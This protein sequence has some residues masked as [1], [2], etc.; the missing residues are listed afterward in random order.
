MSSPY[1]IWS[2]HLE[3][4]C[5]ARLSEL[6]V[7]VGAEESHELWHLDNLNETSLVDIEMSPGLGEVG[8]EVVI[9]HLAGETLVGSENLSGGSHGGGLVHPEFSAWLTTGLE[10]IVVCD[11][12]Q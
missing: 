10:A 6:H 4:W 8:G 12:N 2:L 1:L 3:Q 5:S 11:Q 9:E 7:L